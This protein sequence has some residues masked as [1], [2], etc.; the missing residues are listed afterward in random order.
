MF[1]KWIFHRLSP[2]VPGLG[3]LGMQGFSGLTRV[4]HHDSDIF[5]SRPQPSWCRCTSLQS[6]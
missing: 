6:C 4:V 1:K 3:L 2:W 5:H